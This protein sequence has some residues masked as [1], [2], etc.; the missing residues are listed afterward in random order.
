MKILIFVLSIILS[1]T[2]LPSKVQDDPVVILISSNSTPDYIGEMRDYLSLY[3]FVLNVE[4]EKWAKYDQLEEFAFTLTNTKS[5]TQMS[6]HHKFNALNRNQILMIYPTE[7]KRY[8]SLVT[9]LDYLKSE[10]LKVVINRDIRR[11]K[12]ILH[13]SY[14]KSG[15]PYRESIVLSD[16]SELLDEME[17]TIELL[18]KIKIDQVTR[19]TLSG[20]A[21]TYNGEYLE[22]P[23]GIQLDDMTSDVL[24]EDLENDSKI[25][26]IWSELPLNRLIS[27]STASDQ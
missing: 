19:R 7:E 1:S 18:K 8:K 25:I 22:D 12:P 2:F 14:A 26:N 4:K 10:L 15:S 13:R 3:G 24:I 17:P 20:Y 11:M 16:L 9:G 6:F 21:Y 5:K 23:A 27:G